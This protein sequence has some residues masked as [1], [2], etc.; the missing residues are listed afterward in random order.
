MRDRD[1]QRP[2]D[3]ISS[4]D[5]LGTSHEHAPTSDEIEAA[6]RLQLALERPESVSDLENEDVA[7]ARSLRA[8]WKPGALSPNV[9]DEWIASLPTVRELELAAELQA[10]LETSEPPS[11]VVGLRAAWTPVGLT[12]E[13]NRAIV[14]RAI[15]VGATA[16]RSGAV[17][18]L[19]SSRTRR[20]IAT[21][22][23][24]ALA[25]SVVVWMTAAPTSQG[26]ASLVKARSTT[27]LFDEPFKTGESSARIDRIAMARAS[28]YRAN[29]FAAWGVR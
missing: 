28:D 23:V 16:H 7:L 2:S 20:R 27:P 26:T 3:G 11:L 5:V 4:D 13:A 18:V 10:E 21:S 22:T 24:F 15:E 25:A 6:R 19:G 29:R 12:D 14:S 17:V 9:H 1:S 8:A